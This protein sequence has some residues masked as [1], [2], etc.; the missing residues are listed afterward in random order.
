VHEKKRCFRQYG[1]L[2]H[3]LGPLVS[4]ERHRKS[5]FEGTCEELMLESAVV[6]SANGQVLLSEDVNLK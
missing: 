6:V 3:V 4:L 2:G 1:T 5:A